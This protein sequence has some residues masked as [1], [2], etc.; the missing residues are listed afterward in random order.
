MFRLPNNCV[1]SVTVCVATLI[2]SVRTACGQNSSLYQRDFQTRALPSSLETGSW[3]YIPVPS[4][5][6]VRIEDFVNIRVDQL[7]RMTSLGEVQTRKNN[8]YDA[9][10]RDWIE[11]VGLR[12]IKPSP[13][14]DG[15]QRVRGQVQQQFRAE[16][17]MQT[18]ESLT[19][20]IQAKIVDIRPNGNLVLEAHSQVQVTEEIWDCSL[21]GECRREDV[22]PDNTLLSKHIADLRIQTRARG[23]VRDAYKRGWFQRWFDQFQPF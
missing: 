2:P 20:N 19:F 5:K 15:D 7:S 10:L 14:A 13:Q 23:Q 21:S 18:R 4:A 12:A 17:D 22:G 6:Q 11:L 3:T 16:A 1:I 9:I 8:Q